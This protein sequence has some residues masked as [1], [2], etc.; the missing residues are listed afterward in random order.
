MK[1]KKCGF[2]VAGNMKYCPKCGGDTATLKTQPRAKTS[3]K[4]RPGKEASKPHVQPG[5]PG[6]SQPSQWRAKQEKLR[7]WASDKAIDHYDVLEV[8]ESVDDATLQQRI[9]ALTEQVERMLEDLAYETRNLGSACKTS[10]M[11]MRADL[12]DRL[13]YGVK[14]KQ[15]QHQ[16]EYQTVE[17]MARQ[18]TQDLILQWHEWQTLKSTAAERGLSEDELEEIVGRLKR[19]GVLT[20]ITVD[21]K[22]VRALDELKTACDGRGHRLV[23]VM[24]S[25]ELE[26][27]LEKAGGNQESKEMA[28]WVRALKD[29]YA[30]HQRLGAQV[31]L[32][33]SGERRLVLKGS[34]GDESLTSLADWVN[35]MYNRG[36]EESSIEALDDGR[37]E[38]WLRVVLNQGTLGLMA[39]GARNQG[40]R[41]LWQLV[42]H[43]RERSSAP[44][45]AYNKTKMLVRQYPDFLEAYYQH[46]VH[47]AL[48]SRG[49]EAIEHLKRVIEKDIYIANAARGEPAFQQIKSEVEELFNLSRFQPPA[50]EPLDDIRAANPLTF[51]SGRIYTVGELITMCD[52]YREEAETYLFK[53]YFE[54]WLADQAGELPLAQ[55]AS[56]ISKSFKGQKLRG[57]ELFVRELCK[58][59]GRNPYPQLAAQP[60]QLNFGQIPIGGQSVHSIILK[61]NGRG[62]AWG[63]VTLNPQL[64]GL[65]VTSSFN[66]ADAQLSVEVDALHAVAGEY[67]TEIVVRAEDVPN[68]CVIPLQ[69]QVLPL[70]V[71]IEPRR[72][73][74]GVLL[75]GEKSSAS[76]KLTCVPA[77]G[78]LV[79]EVLVEP[80][81]K[82]VNHAGKINGGSTEIRVNVDTALME[83]GKHYETK[84]ILNTNIGRLEIPVEFQTRLASNVVTK[85]VIGLSLAAGGGMGMLRALLASSG[86][87]LSHWFLSFANTSQA[88]VLVASGLLGAVTIGTLALLIKLKL[89]R[90]KPVKG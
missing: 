79:G 22:E 31:W 2:E 37:L 24:W 82:G 63:T 27:W 33:R 42:W 34:N 85:W 3:I 28:A 89:K 8:D 15:Q 4:T 83:T 84:V 48:T 56:R 50:P 68:P 76:A 75:R 51:K 25:G 36:L 66:K 67:K 57:L 70:E 29:F 35:G 44:E 87:G 78:R 60:A 88:D 52:K 45:A 6:T 13:R 32:W 53:G 12:G 74:L 20:G 61:N 14:R 41:G 69:Y 1:C 58:A 21:G 73:D 86:S 11:E 49:T 38:Q 39:E 30:K 18:F 54:R 65:S 19:A 7:A 55:E 40:S 16:R 9:R 23:G 81:L 43:S 77:T 72:L 5:A 90:S 47:C 64:P 71:H 17:A 46:A 62:H 59:R 26:N 80:Q 10:L